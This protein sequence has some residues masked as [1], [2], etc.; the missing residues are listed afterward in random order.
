MPITRELAEER[1]AKVRAAGWAVFEW[2][3]YCDEGFPTAE[4]Y[5]NSE[6]H[7]SHK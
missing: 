3:E 4:S 6:R 7:G 5:F 2:C 1:K